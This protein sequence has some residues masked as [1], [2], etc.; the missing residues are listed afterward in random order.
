MGLT[1]AIGLVGLASHVPWRYRYVPCRTLIFLIVI[2]I[3]DHVSIEHPTRHKNGRE[4]GRR[5][6]L[7]ASALLPRNGNHN[8][9]TAANSASHGTKHAHK[10]QRSD[11]P[12]KSPDN[13]TRLKKQQCGVRVSKT[14]L[15]IERTIKKRKVRSS[16]RTGRCR[17]G[18]GGG[19]DGGHDAILS[20]EQ[21]ALAL[22][23]KLVSSIDF[24]AEVERALQSRRNT[25][26]PGD[27]DTGDLTRVPQSCNLLRV[28]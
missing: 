8:E 24:S 9:P 16:M 3:L 1:L 14:S 12:T 11:T 6:V 19:H 2:L 15:G 13:N 26:N 7:I 25:C 20:R 22:V 4:A 28:L 5:D 17:L 18:Y 10:L 27:R 21:S 23:S